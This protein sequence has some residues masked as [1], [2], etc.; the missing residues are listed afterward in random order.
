MIK[1][2]GDQISKLSP[3]QAK[4]LKEY[5]KDVYGIEGPA[6]VGSVKIENIVDDKKDEAPTSFDV[7]LVAAGEK[8][9]SIIKE[10]RTI[11]GLGLAE[12]KAAVEKV[13]FTIKEAATKEEA[14]KIKS[15]IE[16]NGGK[17]ELK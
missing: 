3:Q 2:I 8:K 16:T 17:V 13:P 10:I 7:I 5:L 15:I 9:L 12:S 14:E 6:S 11:T 1:E 4:N